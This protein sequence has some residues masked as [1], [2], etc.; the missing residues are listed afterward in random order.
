M[1]KRRTF[2]LLSKTTFIY[3]VFTFI[4]F[5]SSALFLTREA[6]EFIDRELE[7]RFQKSEHRLTHYL[8]DGRS[9]DNLPKSFQVTILTDSSQIAGYPIYTDTLIYNTEL[10]EYQLYRK[11]TTVIKANHQFYRFVLMKS[12]HDYVRLRDDIFGSLIPAFAFLAFAVVLFNY[13]LSGYFFQPFNA[14]LRL[15]RTY[16]VGER[17]KIRKINTST[18]EFRKMQDL[19]HQM[20]DRIEND[21]QNLKEYTENMAHEIQTPLTIIRNKTENLIAD[22]AVMRR[23]SETVKMIYEETNHLS[24]LG[25]TL[26]LI[27][28]IENNEFSNSVLTETKPVIDKHL[29]AISE[30]LQ[31]KS[32]VLAKKLNATHQLYI[33]PYLLDIVLKNLLR[34]AVIYGTADGPITVET[35]DVELMIS[36]YGPPLNFPPEKIFQRFRHNNQ[37]QASLGLG[38]ALVQ[39]ICALNNLHIDYHYQDGQHI[40]KITDSQQ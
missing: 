12:I 10:D 11:K 36:N 37:T 31:L 6:E 28:K 8:G 24:K 27:T 2:N 13:F 29:A 38:L 22:E 32:L 1:N 19:F 33:D 20:I 16:K 18:T 39:K 30:L 3:L 23:Q 40:F 4:A 15:M 7:F 5:F 26:N 25:N 35:S 34:N 17:R 9:A 14:I 21:Y